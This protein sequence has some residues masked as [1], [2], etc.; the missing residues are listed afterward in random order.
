MRNVL[1]TLGVAAAL[2]S[3]SPALAA[4]RSPAEVPVAVITST[5]GA[6]KSSVLRDEA[7]YARAEQQSPQVADFTG[8]SYIMIA[9]STTALVLAIVLLVILL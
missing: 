5:D 4:P 7:R 3:A 2:A 1:M 6:V 9:G 8:G